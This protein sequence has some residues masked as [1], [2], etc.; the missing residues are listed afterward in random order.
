MVLAMDC[1]VFS[2]RAE[3]QSAV[4]QFILAAISQVLAHDTSVRVVLS[5]GGTPKVAYQ[6]L[7]M[8]NIPFERIELFQADERNVPCEHPDSNAHMLKQALLSNGQCFKAVHFFDTTQ[9]WENA[10]ANY[11]VLLQSLAVPLFHLTI[12]GVG[13]DGHTASLF[14]HCNALHADSLVAT[15]TTDAFA[16]HERLTLT[17]KAFMQS[18]KVLILATGAEKKSIVERFKAN[19]ETINEL[20][21]LCV[22]N[23]TD[24][25]VMYCES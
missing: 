23:H 13:P 18:E 20:P 9:T 7:G 11:D 4:D 16:V 3:W 21:I 1:Q 5:G 22:R 12:L 10:A 15:S 25:T 8:S 2:H 14:P 19:T 24:V 17:P 6:N